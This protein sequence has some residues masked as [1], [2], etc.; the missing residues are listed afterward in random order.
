MSRNKGVEQ[1]GE[2]A[3]RLSQLA[4]LD[5]PRLVAPRQSPEATT[6]APEPPL[7]DVV[8]HPGKMYVLSGA[9][10]PRFE[11]ATWL[12]PARRPVS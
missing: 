12:R 3:A 7:M 10:G 2:F 4:E 6:P 5:R 1:P 11:N 8:V 9:A